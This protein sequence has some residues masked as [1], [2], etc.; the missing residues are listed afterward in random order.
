MRG[1]ENTEPIQRNSRTPSSN[2]KRSYNSF[3][4]DNRRGDSYNDG[5]GD[6]CKKERYNND[7]EYQPCFTLYV[8]F[9]QPI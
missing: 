6:N 1:E 9:D 5:R 2:D 3:R 4:R 7:L 8:Q